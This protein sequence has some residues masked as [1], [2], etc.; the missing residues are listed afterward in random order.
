M[1]R[2]ADMH[3]EELCACIYFF[4]VSWTNSVVLEC[5]HEPYARSTPASPSLVGVRI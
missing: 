1:R 2:H 4:I 3:Y 5:F